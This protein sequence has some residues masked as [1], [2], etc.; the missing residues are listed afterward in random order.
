[1]FVKHDGHS[2]MWDEL[3]R[4]WPSYCQGWSKH[5]RSVPRQRTKLL[6][7]ADIVIIVWDVPDYSRVWSESSEMI[8]NMMSIALVSNSSQYAPL[9]YWSNEKWLVV[10][11]DEERHC[12]SYLSIRATFFIKSSWDLLVKYFSMNANCSIRSSERNSS[13]FSSSSAKFLRV[14]VN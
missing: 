6:S 14:P 1:M 3:L 4:S 13:R 8:D 10:I 5:E 11:L 7:S 2:W 9:I 12:S